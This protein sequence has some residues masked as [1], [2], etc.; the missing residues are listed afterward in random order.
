MKLDDRTPTKGLPNWGGLISVLD[1][2]VH[3]PW[4]SFTGVE[5]GIWTGDNSES[6]LTRYQRL[7][8]ITV[9]PFDSTIPCKNKIP[10]EEA[11]KRAMEKLAPYWSRWTHLKLYSVQ[12]AP[13]FPDAFFD[14]VFI[15][16]DHRYEAVKADITAWMPKVRHCGIIAGHDY[17]VPGRRHPGVKRAVNEIFGDDVNVIPMPCTVWWRKV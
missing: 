11:E 5:I 1:E 10:F 14:F 7:N 4:V 3:K 9:D 16:A 12:A 2:H 13:W 8:L 17:K 6:L 15:D